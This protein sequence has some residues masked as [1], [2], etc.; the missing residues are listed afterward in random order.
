MTR[1]IAMLLVA[2]VML[3]SGSP[4]RADTAGPAAIG[5]WW[6]AQQSPVPGLSVPPPPTVPPGGLYVAS[7]PSQ[8]QAISALRYAIADGAT[9]G[10]LTLSIATVQGIGDVGACPATGSW[11]PTEAGE[12]AARPPFDCSAASV[13]AVGDDGTTITFDLTQLS[14]TSVIDVVLVPLR[15]ANGNS[16]ALQMAFD[17]PGP[18]SLSF[19]SPPAPGG[20]NPTEGGEQAGTPVAAPSEQAS[21]DIAPPVLPSP[22]ALPPAALSNPIDSARSARPTATPVA[23]SPIAGYSFGESTRFQLIAAL[24]ALNLAAAAV[25]S[26]SRPRRV[27]M[28]LGTHR[29]SPDAAGN[30]DRVTPRPLVAAG[31]VRGLGRYRTHRPPGE[32][33]RI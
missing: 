5:W 28:L 9:P 23:S 18:S 21:F 6:L 25:W 29:T 13:G 11:A 4:A 8:T 26:Q 32:R 15:D 30:A 24:L 22:G 19:Q 20:A 1:R 2:A 7:D 31:A 3:G 16:P 10:T 27:P 17:P 33:R 12:W 14:S